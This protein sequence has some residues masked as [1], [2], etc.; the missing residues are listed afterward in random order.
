MKKKDKNK[1]SQTGTNRKTSSEALRII[2]QEVKYE[3]LLRQKEPSANSKTKKISTKKS[4]NSKSIN[5][6]ATEKDTLGVLGS[7][8]IVLIILGIILKIIHSKTHDIVDKFPVL[9]GILL[10]YEYF[11]SSIIIRITDSKIVEKIIYFS[12]YSAN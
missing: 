10:K 12:N 8:I 1:Q 7:S 5:E 2:R 9:E 6:V 4:E 11:I 3:T